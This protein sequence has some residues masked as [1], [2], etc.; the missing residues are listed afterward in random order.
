MALRGISAPVVGN[1]AWTGVHDLKLRDLEGDGRMEIVVAADQLYDGVIEIYGFNS[2]NT[3]TLKWTNTT[4]RSARPFTF[5]E[6]ADL[7]G[8]GTPEIIA[9]TP[10]DPA[11]SVCLHLRLSL[12]RKSL[13][14]CH[15]PAASSQ[16]TGLVVEDIDGNGSKEIA[17]L[18]WPMATFTRLMVLPGNWRAS[19][20]RLAATITQP[21]PSR[22]V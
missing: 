4:P 19:C 1:L 2:S 8:N 9:A 6:V 15:S 13:A 12:R 18:V 17:V 11:R 21:S 5:V 16:V 3:F 20:S 22:P 10:C 14:F 7:D